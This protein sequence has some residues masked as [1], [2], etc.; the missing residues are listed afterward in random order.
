MS[1]DL[2]SSQAFIWLLSIWGINL[3]VFTP[4]LLI[5]ITEFYRERHDP[6]L[7][8]RRPIIVILIIIFALFTL[9]IDGPLIIFNLTYKYILLPV[10]FIWGVNSSTF[11]FSQF[12]FLRAWILYFDFKSEEHLLDLKWMTIVRSHKN[13][14]PWTLKY[15]YLGNST[16]LIIL[17]ILIYLIFFI[18]GTVIT[19]VVDNN[20]I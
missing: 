14:I 9:L 17:S 16:L 6:F 20:N 11:L 1:S 15:K 12:L 7:S 5:A 4:F 8:K 3:F 13:T 10:I 18:I 19:S 2:S